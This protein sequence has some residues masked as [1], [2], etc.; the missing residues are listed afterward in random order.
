M[1][2]KEQLRSLLIRNNYPPFVINTE[3]EKY[4][5]RNS[6]VNIETITNKESKT[7]YLSLPYINDKSEK[8]ALKLQK[9]VKEYFNNINLRI[10]FKA[11]AQL[12]DHF[13]F[14]DKVE[15]PSKMSNV[16]YYL[17]CKNC[18]ASYIG[19]STRICSHRMHE[20]NGGDPESHVY[21]HQINEKHEID[22]DNI[23][24]LDRASNDNKL[25]WKEMLYIRKY[26]PSLNVQ[27]DS[28]LF[29]LIIRNT[30]QEDSITRDFQKYSKKKKTIFYNKK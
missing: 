4:E 25:S 2:E 19:K 27:K 20:H 9:T 28:Q 11:P 16:V 21:L 30:K 7:K 8:I 23:K 3:F 13:P 1:I 22:F 29:T 18:D 26:N 5:K 14:K 24:I 17:K 6:F 12:S 10:A 15:D